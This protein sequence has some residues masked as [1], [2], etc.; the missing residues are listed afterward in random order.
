MK[1]KTQPKGQ[2][3]NK[4]TDKPKKSQPWAAENGKLGGRPR[5]FDENRL[6]DLADK[7]IE[8]SKSHTACYLESFCKIYE[9]WPQKLAEY[10]DRDTRFY[11]ALKIARSNLTQ[12][13]AE[14]TAGGEMPPAFGIFALKN[15]GKW[16]D[17]TEIEHSGEVTNTIQL[18]I[19][20]KKPE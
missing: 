5:L 11:A 8:W 15:V 12:N 9:L 4:K 6:A 13:L 10:A 1:K 18:Y 14:S 3:D 20:S 19:P 2:S 17:R 16:T 7:L